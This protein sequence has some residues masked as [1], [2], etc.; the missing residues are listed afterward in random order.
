M[1]TK[2]SPRIFSLAPVKHKP[3]LAKTEDEGENGVGAITEIKLK[4]PSA[5]PVRK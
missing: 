4:K 1:V 3:P 2:A 5:L